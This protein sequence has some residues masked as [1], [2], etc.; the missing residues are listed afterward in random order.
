MTPT[1]DAARFVRAAA[2]ALV[3]WAATVAAAAAGPTRHPV[4]LQMACGPLAAHGY[5]EAPLRIAG[6]QEQPVKQLLGPGDTLL[7]TGLAGRDVRVGQQYYVRR[8]IVPMSLGAP[9]PGHPVPVQTAGWVRITDVRAYLALATVVYQCDGFLPGD[10]LEPFALPQPPQPAPGA[11]RVDLA[12]AGRVLFGDEGREM[13][14]NGQLIVINRGQ[15]HGLAAGDRLTIFRE[16]TGSAGPA[17]TIAEALV[18]SVQAETATARIQK[19]RDAVY[20]GDRVAPSR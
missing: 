11:G 17:V 2:G 3:V 16:P 13:A 18:L 15:A 7:V 14:A 20:A 8:L 1:S 4:A 6:S 9:R 12:A 5:P 10:H 19:T